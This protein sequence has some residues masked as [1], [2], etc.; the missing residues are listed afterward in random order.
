MSFANP[1]HQ[2]EYETFRKHPLPDTMILILGVIDNM[3]KHLE[4]P[5]VVAERILRAVDVVGERSRVIASVDC[6]FAVFTDNALVTEDICWTKFR[7]LRDGAA[8]AS[9]RLWG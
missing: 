2:H 3:T 5:E 9:R 1:G 8:L 6:G 4:H 7:A